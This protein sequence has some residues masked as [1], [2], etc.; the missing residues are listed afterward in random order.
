MDEVLKGVGPRLRSIRLSRDLTLG[1]VAEATGL[2]A[3]TLSRLESGGR[4]PTLELLLALSALYDLPLDDLVG[5]PP[6][7][8]PRV[9]PRPLRRNGMT[10]VPLTHF[11]GPQQALKMVIPSTKSTPALRRHDGYEW[12]YV[13]SGELR[14]IVG[15]HDVLLT[16]G[17]AAEFD[18]T[19]PHWFGSTGT[20]AVEVLSLL[21]LRGQ[22][23]HLAGSVEAN[24]GAAMHNRVDEL[25]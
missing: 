3:S 23:I 17:Q 1:D 10:V 18:T 15:D 24:S 16:V 8:D 20:S 25:P 6:V 9:Y 21:G 7:G 11:P 4:R 13:L 5:A 22:R 2:S 14:L 12:L 19:T